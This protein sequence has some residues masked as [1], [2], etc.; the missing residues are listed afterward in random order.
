MLKSLRQDKVQLKTGITYKFSSLNFENVAHL[1]YRNGTVQQVGVRDIRTKYHYAALPIALH[2]S[3]VTVNRFS[4]QVF[5]GAEFS[6]LYRVDYESNSTYD[7]STAYNLKPK[8]LYPFAD[9]GISLYFNPSDRIKLLLKPT[10]SY[11]FKAVPYAD[12][13][14]SLG[15]NLE[16]YYSF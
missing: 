13:R 2:Y 14:N 3:I 4:L 9:V 1:T 16:I 10:Y 12:G 6:Y 7:G 8:A 11:A 5:G 15:A